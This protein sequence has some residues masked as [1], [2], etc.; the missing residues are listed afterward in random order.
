M[1]GTNQ[2]MAVTISREQRPTH[3]RWHVLIALILGIIAIFVMRTQLAHTGAALRLFELFDLAT[4]AVAAFILFFGFRTLTR[5]D[6]MVGLGVGLFIALTLPLATLF[7]PYPFLDRVHGTL[8]AAVVRGA[9]TAITMLGGLV[10]MHW[11]GPVRVQLALNGWRR[12]LLG[13]GFGAAVGVPLAVL[14]AYANAWTQGQPFV[15]QSVGAAALDALQPALAEEVITRL[16]LLGILW[17][18]LRPFWPERQAIGLAAS[19][20]LLI[21]TYGH[22]SE[23][24]VTQPFVALVMGAVMGL[25]WGLPIT[26]LALRRDIESAIGFH[27]MQDFAR[28]V[29]GL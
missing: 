24:F 4:T 3:W 21:H 28:F 7:N 1:H 2:T 14:N 5:V 25:I 13:F 6:W 29:V 15:W 9:I 8:S 10:I 20:A 23:L 12:A 11:G 19:L 22:Y 26:V 17:L 18:I 27:W 16:A